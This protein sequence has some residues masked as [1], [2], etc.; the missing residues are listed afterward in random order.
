MR[1]YRAVYLHIIYKYE[2][3]SKNTYFQNRFQPN[4]QTHKNFGPMKSNQ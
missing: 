1:Y 4:K 3:Q 2:I